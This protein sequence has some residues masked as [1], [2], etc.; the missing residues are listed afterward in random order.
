MTFYNCKKSP[1]N[2]PVVEPSISKNVVKIIWENK[3]TPEVNKVISINP[4]LINDLVITSFDLIS[5][6][7]SEKLVS[8]NNVSG[9][10]MWEWSDYIRPSPQFIRGTETIKIVDNTLIACSSQDNY[11]INSLN[12]LSIWA[13][14]I[15]EG[16]PRIS[17]FGNNVFHTFRYGNSPFIDSTEIVMANYLTGQWQSLFKLK[18]IDYNPMLFPP[19]GY[20]NNEGD[21]LLI[22]Q[23]QGITFSPALYRTDL[24][25]YN[26]TQDSIVWYKPNFTPSGSSNVRAPIVEGNL[27]YFAGK[28]DFYCIDIVSGEVIWTHN[29]YWDYQ[30]SNFLIFDDLIIT[31]LDNGDLIAIDKSTG[32]QVWVNVGLSGCCTELRIY[33]DRIYFGN[34]QLYIIDANNGE[35]LY[36]LKSPNSGGEFNNAIAVDLN[37]DKMYTTDGYYIMC[38]ELPE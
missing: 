22:F 9:E 10:L 30:N 28:W 24:R 33:D 12:G 23:T 37:N 7:L 36:K 26:L 25:C 13:T 15:E 18:D 11:A 20:L 38:M 19:A 34:D 27:V 21:I 5:D 6:D 17:T 8:F 4:I 31:N 32:N 14:N 1:L 29:F 16:R 3:L 35:L 2:K